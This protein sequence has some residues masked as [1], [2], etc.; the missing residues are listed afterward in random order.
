MPLGELSPDAPS[1]PAL[2]R[3]VAAYYGLDLRV[4]PAVPL[5]EVVATRRGI[6]RYGDPAQLSSRDVL[7]WLAPLI[8]DDGY[9]LLAVTMMDLYP[10]DDWNYVFGQASFRD[11]VGV[12]SFA[13]QDPAFYDE[14]RG[15]DWRQLV[16]RRAAWTVIHELGHTFG[17]HHCIYFECVF[18]GANHQEEADHRPLHACPVCLRKLHAA[19]GFD[20]AAREDALATVFAELG[21]ADEAAW[22]KRR[23]T[24]I[25]TGTR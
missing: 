15:P 21:L 11:R 10:A 14:P 9:T 18:S 13:R 4:L 24:W 23:A 17:L 7:R 5:G 22:S 2:R 19:L 12:Q 8:P 1:L 3:I 6:D 16:L 25:R 20:P